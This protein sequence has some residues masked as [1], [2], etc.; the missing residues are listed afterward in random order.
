MAEE[1]ESPAASLAEVTRRGLGAAPPFGLVSGEI[2]GRKECDE[3]R[4]RPREAISPQKL[5]LARRV[6]KGG[7]ERR[8]LCPRPGRTWGPA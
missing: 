4:L 7:S 3:G 2:W 6:P 1:G 5:L 8:R